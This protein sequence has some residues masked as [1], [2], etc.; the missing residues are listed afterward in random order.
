M[1][2]FQR[3]VKSSTILK[4]ARVLSKSEQ[5]KIVLV[6]GVQLFLSV[7]DLIGVAIVGILSA[8]AVRGV[9]SQQPGDRVS[10]VLRFLQIEDLSFQNQM[11]VLGLLAACLLIAR[12]IASIYL[13]RKTLFFLS[14]RGATISARLASQLLS[15]S[16]LKVQNRTN[17]LT[18]FSLTNGVEIVVLKI[19]GTAVTLVSDL[20]LLVVMVIG[21]FIVDPSIAISSILLFGLVGLALYK[22]MHKRAYS[23]GLANHNYAIKINEKVIEVLNSYRESTV[24]NRRN[25]Y[26]RE[27]AELRMKMADTSAD[28]T[29]MPSISKYVME[30]TV[31]IG[32]LVIAGIQFMTKDAVQAVSTLSV[33]LAAGTRIAPAA[34]RLQQGAVQIKEASGSASSTL[35]L[36]EELRF[37]EIDEENP[38]ILNL[39]HQ[40]FIPE[41]SIRD[42]S[43]TYPTKNLPAVQD[44]NLQIPAGSSLAFVGP[45]GAGKTT[46]VDM[47]LGVLSPDQ[48]SIQISGHNPIDSIKKWPGAISYVPQDVMISNGTIRENIALG[49]PLEV[50]TDQLVYAALEIADLVDFVKSLPKGLDTEVGERGTKISGGQRQRLGIARAMFTNPSLLVLDEATSSL[51]GE[52][53]LKVSDA[54]KGLGEN[55][56]VIL[57][58]HRLST[59]KDVDIVVYM[60]EG[61]IKAIGKF[62]EVRNKVTDFDRQA[63]LMGL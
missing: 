17:Q 8:L 43:L 54:I 55:T 25:Y 5:R 48:G 6:I 42:A 62:D 53:E 35:A 11:V 20:S 15:Q 4:C 51:D 45:S 10:M 13:N 58:A 61:R 14:R 24:R 59:V 46:I 50:A 32:A 16:L 23:L 39:N 22:L 29:F 52:T 26:A 31:V 27:I 30:T 57:I 34:L 1:R 44:L 41:I 12:T 7:L 33:F 21:L 37:I 18:L 2:V 63:Q 49:Y 3:F 19:L 9:Q 38:D 40:G 36:I 56:T 47:I 60:A 28:M